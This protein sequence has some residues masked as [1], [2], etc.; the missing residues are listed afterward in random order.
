MIEPAVRTPLLQEAISDKNVAIILL[1]MVLGY[2]AHE[3]PAAEVVAAI[4]A[5]QGDKPLMIASV[6]GTDKDPQNYQNQ[7]RALES[8]GVIVCDSNSEAAELCA[9][10]LAQNKRSS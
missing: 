9:L 10:L 8:A 4:T 5:S 3:D 1:D 7:C 6:C 2:G